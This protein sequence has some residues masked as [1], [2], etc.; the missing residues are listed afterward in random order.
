MFY[1]CSFFYLECLFPYQDLKSGFMN[2]FYIISVFYI[3]VYFVHLPH[4]NLRYVSISIIFV[5]CLVEGL[6]LQKSKCSCCIEDMKDSPDTDV[7]DK[8]GNK[9]KRSRHQ[10][11][12]YMTKPKTK[13]H[14]VD[15]S[16]CRHDTHEGF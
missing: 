12:E 10:I 8:H 9:L 13:C 1:M 11:I 4:L 2:C 6:N 14:D 3:T 7:A 5:A 15:W 16:K